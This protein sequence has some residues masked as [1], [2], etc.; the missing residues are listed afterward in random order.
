[1][2]WPGPH[3]QNCE[4]RAK[5]SKNNVD[6]KATTSASAAG[7]TAATAIDRDYYK[8]KLQCAIYYAIDGDQ[9]ELYR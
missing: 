4:E 6:G 7:A 1:M 5:R 8:D 3:Q 2:C 9:V